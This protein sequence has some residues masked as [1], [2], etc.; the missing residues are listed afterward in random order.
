MKQ[1]KIAVAVLLVLAVSPVSAD[2]AVG[3]SKSMYHSCGVIG[4]RL[5]EVTQNNCLE[6]P[7]PFDPEVKERENYCSKHARDT[8]VKAKTL[9]EEA[10]NRCSTNL[11]IPYH[12]HHHQSYPLPRAMR[13]LLNRTTMPGRR[14]LHFHF[15]C[16]GVN[17]LAG[18]YF[19]LPLNPGPSN[20]WSGRSSD[21]LI[22]ID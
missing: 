19:Y 8:M 1:L 2:S 6:S 15:V 17:S 4:W 21:S 12:L 9:C 7:F 22:S 20:P 18:P 16:Y 13:R 3:N 14:I 10:R 5:F 11:G